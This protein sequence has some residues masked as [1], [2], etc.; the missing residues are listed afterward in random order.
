MVDETNISE[1]VAEAVCDILLNKGKRFMK[2]AFV[3]AD[4]PT[5]R[6]IK[7]RLEARDFAIEFFGDTEKAKEWLVWEK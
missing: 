5:V 1:R 7:K 2:A 6:M 4:R 3:G